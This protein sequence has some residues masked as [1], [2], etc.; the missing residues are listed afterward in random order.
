[1]V[2]LRHHTGVRRDRDV[3]QVVRGRERL[4]DRRLPRIVSR[5]A[6]DRL[7]RRREQPVDERPGRAD[8][9]AIGWIRGS[10]NP[11]SCR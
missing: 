1:M 9:T 3:G 8:A 6:V 10:G 4:D 5:R 7:R 2:R 11:A